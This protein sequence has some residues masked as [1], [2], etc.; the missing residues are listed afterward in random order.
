MSHVVVHNYAKVRSFLAE[1]LGRHYACAYL[2]AVPPAPPLSTQYA[3]SSASYKLV[4]TWAEQRG[5]V[6]DREHAAFAVYPPTMLSTW[7]TSLSLL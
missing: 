3:R 2:T 5:V 6:I 7:S 4:G 1:T